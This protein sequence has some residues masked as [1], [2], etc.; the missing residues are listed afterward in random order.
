MSNMKSL[1]VGVS[2]TPEVGLEVAQIDFAT[3]TVLKYGIRKLE[4]DNVRR[5]IADLDLFKEALQDLFMELAIAQG[6]TVVINIP[7]VTF[8]VND[9]PAAL[10]DGQISNALE[11]DVA[12]HPILKNTEPAISAV[13]LPNSS[14]QFNKIAYVAAQKQMLIEMALI[15]KDLGYKLYAIDTSVNS[16]LNALMYKQRVDVSE[17][18]NW[19]LLTVDNTHCRIL[20]MNGKDYV[21]SYEEKISIDVIN[22]MYFDFNIFFNSLC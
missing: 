19:V 16:V 5:E 2:V 6:S 9:Y 10:E 7:T 13:K 1:V 22:F 20:S 3:Q 21:D 14:M 15:I 12:D 8:K 4:Y 18:V 17:D 11:E